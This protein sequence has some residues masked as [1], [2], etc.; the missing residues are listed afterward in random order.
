MRYLADKKYAVIPLEELVHRHEAG[1]PLG[2]SV[3][4][5]FDD[6]YRDNFVV[7]FPI[8][9]NY[10]FPATIFV[11]TDLMGKSDKRGLDRMSIE[12]LQQIERSGLVSIEPHTKSHPRLSQL[13][14]EA[15]HEEV[16]GS[17]H[18]LEVALN[19]RCR[20][21]AP[22]YGAYNAETLEL[23]R[24]SGIQA[25]F[26]VKEGTV[27]EGSALLELPRVSV[28]RSTTWTQFRGKLSTAVD[29][30]QA[31]KLWQ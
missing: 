25:S 24:A 18:F 7:A 2:G 19:K 4:I 10:N 23:L 29:R 12:D 1:E 16:V 14:T 3:V 27:S 26:T 5:T 15:L 22:P 17:K 9:K 13:S 6:G 11:T 8:L 30:Y 31:I 28:D 21:F 20:F